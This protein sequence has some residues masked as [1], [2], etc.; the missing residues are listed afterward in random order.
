[1][2]SRRKCYSFEHLRRIMIAFPNTELQR[3]LQGRRGMGEPGIPG[4]DLENKMWTVDV[5]YSCRK[6]GGGSSRL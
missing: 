1:M 4:K 5:R 2:I 3:T 6:M